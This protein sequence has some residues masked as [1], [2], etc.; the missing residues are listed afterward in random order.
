[1]DCKSVNMSSQPVQYNN[2]EIAVIC[3]SSDNVFK[4]PTSENTEQTGLVTPYMIF[5]L[6]SKQ[7]QPDGTDVFAI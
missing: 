5:A 7:W 2:A 6:H 4:L 1:M 3:A